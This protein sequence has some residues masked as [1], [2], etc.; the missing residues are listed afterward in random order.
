MYIFSQGKF[1][2]FAR[3]VYYASGYRFSCDVQNITYTRMACYYRGLHPQYSFPTST[4]S[5]HNTCGQRWTVY[6]EGLYRQKTNRRILYKPENLSKKR[7]TG[8]RCILWERNNNT[9]YNYL[10][11]SPTPSRTEHSFF[12]KPR[13]RVFVP[14]IWYTTGH[15]VKTMIM[16]KRTRALNKTKALLTVQKLAYRPKLGRYQT[17]YIITQQTCMPQPGPARLW[18]ICSV[19]MVAYDGRAE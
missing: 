2:I 13:L 1:S 16:C 9:L 17:A 10:A 18:L 6:M 4:L 19:P 14:D 3:F 7:N 15:P 11:P 5:S 12:C 8:D